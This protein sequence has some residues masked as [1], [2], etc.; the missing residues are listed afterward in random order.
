MVKKYVGVNIVLGSDQIS[1]SLI[2]ERG[3]ARLCGR[4]ICHVLIFI[5]S[6]WYVDALPTVSSFVVRRGTD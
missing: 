1:A 4:G 5:A 6:A 3:G 2:T